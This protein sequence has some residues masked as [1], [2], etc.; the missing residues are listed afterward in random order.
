[1]PGK[2]KQLEKDHLDHLR[3]ILRPIIQDDFGGNTSAFC[4]KVGI[5][6]PQ[7]SALLSGRTGRG[8]GIV[9][10]LALR[11]YLRMS[12]D[13][14]LGLTTGAPAAAESPEVTA[15]RRKLAEG[16]EEVRAELADMKRLA[17]A[18]TRSR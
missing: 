14:M 16:L 18:K 15:E 6:Q 10:L 4:R 13:E 8:V 1:M 12:I 5:P 7:M 2:T 3:A 17:L 9:G 11:R